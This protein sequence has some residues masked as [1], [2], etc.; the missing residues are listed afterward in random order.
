MQ[1]PDRAVDHVEEDCFCGVQ[2]A[3][4]S[5]WRS[6]SWGTMASWLSSKSLRAL[7]VA[8]KSWNGSLESTSISI[9]V[10]NAGSAMTVFPL[11]FSKGSFITSCALGTVRA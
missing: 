1:R 6:K 11:N 10:R 2:W 9:F 8:Q 3:S 7:Q 5:A 4:S